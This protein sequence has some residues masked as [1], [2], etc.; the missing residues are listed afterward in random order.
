MHHRSTQ[1][2]HGGDQWRTL[3]LELETSHRTTDNGRRQPQPRHPGTH[4]SDDLTGSDVRLLLDPRPLTDPH[5]P[6]ESLL[7]HPALYSPPEVLR[8][9]SMREAGLVWM[10][11]VVLHC[12]LTGSFP[13]VQAATW[14]AAMRGPA[15]RVGAMFA[16][17]LL[18]QP[19]ASG[20]LWAHLSPG[21]AALLGALLQRDPARRP[22]LGMLF[23]DHPWV[24]E[25]A[26]FG[27]LRFNDSLLSMESH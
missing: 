10:L 24:A 11:G 12:M 3:E 20:A 21:A 6:A 13:F 7:R 16:A 8:G 17:D 4:Q 14:A 5:A 9:G 18:Q 23:R 22:A 2:R 19:L 1:T 27:A 26:P 25:G 15:E